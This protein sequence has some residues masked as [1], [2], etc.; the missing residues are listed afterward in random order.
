M[1]FLSFIFA[2]KLCHWI[3]FLIAFHVFKKLVVNN[4]IDS[5]LCLDITVSVL[6]SFCPKNIFHVKNSRY[7]IIGEFIIKIIISIHKTSFNMFWKFHKYLLILPSISKLFWTFLALHFECTKV[8]LIF[9]DW[10]VGWTQLIHNKL[11]FGAHMCPS[12]IFDLFSNLPQ[13]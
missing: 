7:I 8:H 10:H 11:N 3:F 12:E 4:W 1:I 2:S 9:Y 5:I 6:G 13:Q